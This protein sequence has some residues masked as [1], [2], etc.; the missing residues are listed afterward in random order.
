MDYSPDYQEF[1]RWIMAIKSKVTDFGRVNI[2]IG[3]YKLGDSPKKFEQEVRFCE[4]CGGGACVI[5][6][7]GS[8]V[9][10]PSLA[11]FLLNR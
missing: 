5:F 4:K 1:S 7:Y 9:D 6:H 11:D 10:N 8:L 2:G 3:A